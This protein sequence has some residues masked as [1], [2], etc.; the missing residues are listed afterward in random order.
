LVNSSLQVLYDTIVRP[1]ND[2]V[3][4]NTRLSVISEKDVKEIKVSV[5]DVQKTL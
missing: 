5:K 2:V 3:D 1:A 4:Y